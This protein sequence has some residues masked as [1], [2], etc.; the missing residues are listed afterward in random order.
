MNGK[1]IWRCSRALSIGSSS[2][3]F[4]TVEAAVADVHRGATLLVGG[5]GLS[6]VPENLIRGVRAL[7]VG[8]LTVRSMATPIHERER[9][10]HGQEVI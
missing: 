5:F 7:G 6:G 4:P 2:K 1:A 3:V 8:D 9:T 10:R